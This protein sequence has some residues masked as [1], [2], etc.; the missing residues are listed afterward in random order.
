[1]TTETARRNRGEDLAAWATGDWEPNE[2]DGPT[3]ET[4]ADY[5]EMAGRTDS[6]RIA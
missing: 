1:M 5:A 2:A 3:P 6:V 4:I